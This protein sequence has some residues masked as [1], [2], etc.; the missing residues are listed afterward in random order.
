MTVRLVL[1]IATL[2]FVTGVATAAGAILVIAGAVEAHGWFKS[3]P[4]RGAVAE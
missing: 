3:R 2:A 4:R 1:F